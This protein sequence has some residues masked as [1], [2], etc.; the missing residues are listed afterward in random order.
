MVVGSKPEKA[1]GAGAE[2]YIAVFTAL[3][4]LLTPY[5]RDLA[6]KIDKP[7]NYY[8]ETRS[9]SLN[10]RRLFFAAVKLKKNYVSFYLTPLFMYPELSDR[11]S[12]ALK[13]MMQ[14][15]SCFNFTAVDQDR[16]DELDRLTQAGFQRIKSEAL[17]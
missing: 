1:A 15:Q 14:G 16:F 13:R 12:P 6:V 5:E 17:L 11:V 10:G 2:R 9:A 7:D 4:Q 3:R 8:L